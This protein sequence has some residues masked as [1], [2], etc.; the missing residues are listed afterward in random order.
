MHLKNRKKQ[1]VS[2]VLTHLMARLPLA[3]LVKHLP[4]AHKEPS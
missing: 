1:I 3:H 4:E 2:E